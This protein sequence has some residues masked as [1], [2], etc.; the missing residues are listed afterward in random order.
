[1]EANDQRTA[2]C[3]ARLVDTASRLVEVVVEVS[4]MAID[5][6]ANFSNYKVTIKLRQSY[7]VVKSAFKI[8]I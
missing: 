8:R 2:L 1:V 4:V 5:W 6:L 7:K 3:A